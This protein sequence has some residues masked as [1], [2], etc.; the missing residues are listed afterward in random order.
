MEQPFVRA[1]G[2][3]TGRIINRR[4]PYE[5]DFEQLIA[6]AARTGTALEI[7]AHYARLDLGDRQARAAQEAGVRLVIN[8]DAHQ[9]ACLDVLKYGVATA[10][11]GWIEASTVLNTLPLA[12]LAS[13]LKH[14]KVPG[15]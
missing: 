14:P 1:I 10:R 8:S 13:L 3:P 12:E 9:P 15:H 2:H 5:V 6:A 4:E 11:R 7:N